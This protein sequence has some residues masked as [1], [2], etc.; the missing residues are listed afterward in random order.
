[1]PINTTYQFVTAGDYVDFFVNNNLQVKLSK[2]SN[3]IAWF[4]DD[5]PGIVFK[6]NGGTFFTGQVE[7]ISFDGVPLGTKEG[8]VTAIKAMFPVYAGGGGSTPGIDTVLAQAQALTEDRDVDL[9]TR[10]IR[11]VSEGVS[12]VEIKPDGLYARA[13]LSFI[14]AGSVIQLKSQDGA[15]W[16]ITVSDLGV[17][18]VTP[19]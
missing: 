13:R 14:D 17:L 7:D 1:M 10:S 15:G 18:V 4:F 12:E 16:N 8:F 3:I 6:V 5:L 11:F 9:A 19:D 2:D